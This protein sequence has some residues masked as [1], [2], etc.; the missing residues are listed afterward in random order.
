[1]LT[2]KLKRLKLENPALDIVPVNG[3]TVKWSS[4]YDNN[5][6]VSNAITPSCIMVQIRPRP[7]TTGKGQNDKGSYSKLVPLN[8]K[9]GELYPTGDEMIK[10]RGLVPDKFVTIEP[11]LKDRSVYSVNKEWGFHNYQAVVDAF[12]DICFV[13]CGLAHT[14]TLKGV[15]RINTGHIR[16]A[17]AVMS[18]AKFH[19][20]VEGGTI[21]AA[22]ALGKQSVAIF[23]GLSAPNVTGYETNINFYTEHEL[24]PCGSHYECDH[25]KWCMDQIKVHDVIEAV[26]T[27]KEK[28]YDE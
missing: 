26:N 7:Y 21:H 4:V 15:V 27:L 22:T 1:M 5:P 28:H 6:N 19:V 11:N 3:S 12:P 23:G 8:P 13:Q 20:G 25:C 18:L 16:E 17:F 9:P 24:S 14:P 2:A 10:A